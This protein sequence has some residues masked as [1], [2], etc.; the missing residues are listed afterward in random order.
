MRNATSQATSSPLS[1]AARKAKLL[2]EREAWLSMISP[3]SHFH[4]LFD[5]IDDVCFF[6]KNRHGKTMLASRGVLTRYGMRDEIEILGTT[7]FDRNPRQMARGYVD[8][9]ARILE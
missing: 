1:D 2:R 8:D 7:D 9:D 5:L 3:D 4:R 6:A